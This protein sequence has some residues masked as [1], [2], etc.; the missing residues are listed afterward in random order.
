MSDVVNI[1]A[2][3]M[4][5]WLGENYKVSSI[6]PKTLFDIQS[7]LEY[8]RDIIVPGSQVCIE[9]PK[10]GSESGPRALVEDNEVIIPFHMLQDGRFDATIGAIIHELHHIKLSPSGKFIHSVAFKFLRELSKTIECG[11]M[12]L[13]ARVFSDASVTVD[14]ILSQKET[15]S[16]EVQFIRKV[17]SDL[18]FLMNAVEDVRIDANTPPNLRKY[19]DKIDAEGGAR[20]KSMFDEG[21]FDGRDLSTISYLLLGHHKKFFHSDYIDGKFGDTD[22]IVNGDALKLP[23]KLFKAFS[24][25]IAAHVLDAYYKFCGQPQSSTTQQDLSMDFDLDAYFGSQVSDEVSNAFD[26]Q[27]D[28]IP[29]SANQS[30]ESAQEEKEALQEAEQDIKEAVE[31]IQVEPSDTPAMGE[32]SPAEEYRQA[33]VKQK[34]SAVMSNELALQVRAFKNIQVY[35]TTQNFDN[36]QVTYDAVLYDA[37]NQ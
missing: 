22:S 24:S 31:D 5:R 4:N 35:T 8:Y 2:E 32:M 33:Q 26:E 7:L 23:G 36:T 12:S 18:L 1:D 19:I 13:N 11:G 15:S 27:I 29:T 25:E 28:D 9:F 10:E 37:T 20:I 16:V 30:S 14:N 21:K 6:S 17:L 34:E 3:Y